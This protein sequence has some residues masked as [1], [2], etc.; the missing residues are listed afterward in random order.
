[1]ISYWPSKSGVSVTPELQDAAVLVGNGFTS[2]E[3]SVTL[4]SAS[5]SLR[6]QPLESGIEE[7]AVELPHLPRRSQV[8]GPRG[9]RPDVEGLRAVAVVAVVL[10]HAGL[11]IRGGYV[12]VDVFFVLSGFLITRQ[13]T[14]AVASKGIRAIPTFYAHRIRRLLPAAAVAVVATVV[15]ARVWAP[16]LQVRGI[17]TDAIFTTFYSLN[18][19]LAELGTD[20]QHVGVAASPLQHF[21]SLGVEEQFYVGWPIV[22]VLLMCVGRRHASVLLTLFLLGVIVV[23]ARLS[24][25]VTAHAAPWAYF[26]LHTRAWELAV[27]ALVALGAR[28]LVRLPR[29]IAGLVGWLGLIAIVYSALA[30]TDETPFPGSAAWLPVGGSALVVAA[31]CGPRV[32]VER[33]LAEPLMQCLGRVSYSWYLWH[34]PMLVLIPDA[35]GHDL[36][37]V[38]RVGVVWLSL[39]AAVSSYFAI[40][41]PP[42]RIVMPNWRWLSAGVGLTSSVTV[43]ALLVLAF[44][45]S[46]TGQGHEVHLAPVAG[47]AAEAPSIISRG[48]LHGIHTVA[49]PRNLTPQPQHAAASVP[50]TSHNGCHAGFTSIHQPDCVYGDAKAQRTVV[51]FGDS[52]IEQWL[53]AFAIAGARRHW[54][55]VNWTKAACPAAWLTVFNPSLNREYTEC[56]E[57]RAETIA[58]IAGLHPRLVVVGQSE[59]VVSSDVSASGFASATIRTLDELRRSTTARVVYLGDIPVPN[60]DLPGCVAEHLDDVRPCTFSRSDAYTY[61]ARHR[62]IG[63]AVRTAR[64]RFVDPAPFFC[65][66]TTC[67]AVVGNVLVYR[68]DTHMTVPYSRWLAPIAIRLLAGAGRGGDRGGR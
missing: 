6:T 61:P 25:I 44:P 26:S 41:S 56:D 3:V 27:G 63:P 51:L 36:T 62:A 8:G 53:P 4:V 49:V 48:I 20:Y 24:V 17:A 23:S 29:P 42:R 31:G 46:T 57:W 34:W 38:E 54:K 66:T 28:H 13:L 2:G 43:C 7:A 52:H 68:N 64:F 67:P 47:S 37:V 11:G 40:E 18:Y 30:Y 39:V 14:G 50:P 16:V 58:R 32:S 15:A 35:L 21:W 12:G 45:R 5:T 60:S 22:I 1:L 33:I 9:F 10:Y 55:V 59:N 65:T 19:R